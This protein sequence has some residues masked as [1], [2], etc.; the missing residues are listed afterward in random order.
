MGVFA[1][2]SPFRPNS[3]GLSLVKLEEIRKDAILVSGVDML[4]NTPIYDIKPYLPYADFRPDALGGFGE[5]FC[6]YALEVLFP[7]ELLNKIPKEK[8]EALISCLREDPRPS[9]HEDLREYRMR[10]L[11]FDIHFRVE[12]NILKVTKIYGDKDD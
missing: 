1:S 3:L 8:Q 9:Y 4:D 10:F 5:E 7:E 2:R 11:D 6:D 12:D